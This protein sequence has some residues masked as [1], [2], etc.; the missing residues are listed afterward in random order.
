MLQIELEQ[1][2]PSIEPDLS[3]FSRPQKIGRG[4][5]CSRGFQPQTGKTLEDDARQRVPVA[6][7]KGEDTDKQR[8]PDKARENV[9][10]RSPCPEQAG[11]RDIDCGQRGSEISDLASEQP[12]PGIDVLGER[13]QKL[14]DNACATHGLLLSGL[15]NRRVAQTA[16]D[17]R[18]LA[19][20]TMKSLLGAAP[21][22]RRCGWRSLPEELAAF[23]RPRLA[24]FR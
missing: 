1:R 20:R 24:A 17:L 6:D 15:L 9:L 13:R 14:I 11:Q 23:L 4:K 19:A 8:L 3:N 16:G 18:P 22:V 5:P 2:P 21:I 7:Q 10:V 12:E